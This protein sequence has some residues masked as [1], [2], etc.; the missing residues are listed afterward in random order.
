MAKA[1]KEFNKPKSRKSQLKNL[2][3]VKKNIEVISKIM[4][5]LQKQTV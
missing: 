3:R 5:Q 1:R 4:N 2:K